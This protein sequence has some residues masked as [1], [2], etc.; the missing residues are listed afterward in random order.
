MVQQ[1]FD[2]D[3]AECRRIYFA[4]TKDLTLKS[5]MERTKQEILSFRY[6]TRIR[7]GDYKQAL[8]DLESEQGLSKRQRHIELLKALTMEHNNEAI[9]G[10]L[11][12]ADTDLLLDD[13]LIVQ[14]LHAYKLAGNEAAYELVKEEA[15]KVFREF[16]AR[17][18]QRGDVNSVYFSVLLA[19]NLDAKEDLD[20]TWVDAVRKVCREDVA[21]HLMMKLSNMKA[22]W[23]GTESAARALAKLK[24]SHYDTFYYLGKSQIKQ[25]KYAEGL[26]SME[27]FLRYCLDSNYYEDALELQKFA[28]AQTGK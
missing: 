21:Q 8:A 18:L 4:R 19:E 27:P 2:T 5:G 16:K 15:Q 11:N 28:R 22:D 17:A 6:R 7:G 26:K 13:G 24:P 14:T 9:D 25:G 20:Q 3:D 12:S 10:Y 23:A 1:L